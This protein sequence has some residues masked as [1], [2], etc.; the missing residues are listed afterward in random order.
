[1]AYLDITN[2]Y[3]EPDIL[4]FREC[5]ALEKIHGTSAHISWKADTGIHFFA[6]GEKHEKFIALFNP[7]ALT[8]KFKSIDGKD[9][10]I[11]GEAYGG[12]QQ[13]MSATYGPML[14]FVV[15][16]VKIDDLWLAV[17]QAEVLTKEFGLEFVHYVKIPADLENINRERDADSVQ[18]K[19]NGIAEPRMREGVVLRP[20]IE[21][22]KNNGER[23]I[24]KHKRDEFMETK[25]PREVD[26]AKLKVLEDARAIADE[27]V[28][29]MRLT[30]VLDKNPASG[31][32]DTPK[33]IKAMLEDVKR[34]AAGEVVWSKDVETAIGRA[35]AVLLKRHFSKT[36]EKP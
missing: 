30:H 34:E 17:P 4:M 24:V 11:Y 25:T 16:D 15:F 31:M 22:R 20:L 6:G 33:V 14:K 32:E 21:L 3:K 2:L 10:V 12:K 19:R 26:P 27:W 8:E 35:T 9:V 36:L 1:M 28:T 5:Y 7:A 18:A 29:P 23:I 13:G